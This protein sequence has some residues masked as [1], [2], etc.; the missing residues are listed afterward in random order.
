MYSFGIELEVRVLD[1]QH[2]AGREREPEADGRTL[3]KV[4]RAVVDVHRQVRTAA[5]ARR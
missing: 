4:D 2:V 1:Q 3:S 5:G